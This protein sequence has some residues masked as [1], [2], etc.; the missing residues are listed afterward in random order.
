[1]SNREAGPT[2]V[3]R[4]YQLLFRVAYRL[5]RPWWKLAR[6]QTRGAFVGIWCK[7]RVL[8]IQNSYVGYRS[9]PGGGVRKGEAPVRAAVRECFEE[10]GVS[11]EEK[12]LTLDFRVEH[13]L[14]GKRDTVWL[15]WVELEEEPQ[16][17]I[18]HREVTDAMFLEPAEAL[19]GP[20][21]FPALRHLRDRHDDFATN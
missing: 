7:G 9:F 11:V 4:G 17:Q 8:V 1:M 6:P 18:D 2:F 10:V 16:V 3:D 21:F 13:R 19:A 12:D 15:Y 5:L 20:L 14:E